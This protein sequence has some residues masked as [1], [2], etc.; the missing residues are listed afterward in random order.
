MKSFKIVHK[1]RT[2]IL[3]HFG[4]SKSET[5]GFLILLVIMLLIIFLPYGYQYFLSDN[6]N[7]PSADQKMLDSLVLVLETQLHQVSIEEKKPELF[8]FDPNKLSLE[9]FRKIGLSNFIISNILK[10]REKGGRFSNKNDLARIYGMND[11]IFS[12]IY[13][14]IDLP[15]E[16]S[17]VISKTVRKSKP[18]SLIISKQT[19]SSLS[20]EQEVIKFD[21]NLADTIELQKIYGIGSVLSNRIIKYRELLGGFVSPAQYQEIYGLDPDLILKLKDHTYIDNSFVPQQVMINFSEVKE[22]IQHPYITYPIGKAIVNYR[23]VNG[24][25]SNTEELKKITEVNDQLFNRL[26]PYIKL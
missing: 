25:F 23:I 21:I 22:L 10:Y 19:G 20:K 12:V 13:P 14:F 9:D 16:K 24:P 3:N 2:L 18:D 5:N 4:F 6:Y 11:S 15:E 8:P 1:I 7:D 17:K 26:K